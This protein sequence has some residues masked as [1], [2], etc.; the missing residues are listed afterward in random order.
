[1]SDALERFAY[2]LM[3]ASA[4]LSPEAVV[5]IVNRIDNPAPPKRTGEL[6]A[7]PAA[8]EPEE[9]PMRKTASGVPIYEPPGFEYKYDSEEGHAPEDDRPSFGGSGGWDAR[10]GFGG[11]ADA[12]AA[13]PQQ[14]FAEAEAESPAPIS[15]RAAPARESARLAPRPAARK[16]K[17]KTYGPFTM[18]QWIV[19]GG[20]LLLWLCAMG[21]FL[22]F[23]LRQ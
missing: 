13:A 10:L 14:V 20:I 11:E 3:Q 15:E 4:S 19:L 8:P 23:I 17:V 9:A 7:A 16:P 22:F 1:M 5:T 2:S 6:A 18:Q 21:V 12:P